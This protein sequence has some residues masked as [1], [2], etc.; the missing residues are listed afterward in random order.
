MIFKVSS[1]SFANNLIFFPKQFARLALLLSVLH[2]TGCADTPNA[3][4]SYGVSYQEMV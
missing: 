3:D 2:V 4:A 1:V